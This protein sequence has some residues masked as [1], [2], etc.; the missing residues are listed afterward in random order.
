MY[1]LRD[2][3]LGQSWNPGFIRTSPGCNF[4]HDHQA[5]TVRVQRFADDLVG[6]VGTIKIAGVDVIDAVLDS[7]LKNFYGLLVVLRWPENAGSRQLH[8]AVAHAID[9]KTT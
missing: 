8:G 9:L 6:D 7:I 2:F 4:G 1:R 5:V 3:F